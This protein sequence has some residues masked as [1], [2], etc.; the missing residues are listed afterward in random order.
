MS[1]HTVFTSD[2]AM[3][4]QHTIKNPSNTIK[5]S[6]SPNV[7]KKKKSFKIKTREL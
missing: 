5:P 4:G 6:L 7:T 3:K 2:P 1:K